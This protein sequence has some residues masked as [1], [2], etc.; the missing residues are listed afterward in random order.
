MGLDGKVAVVTGA[1]RGIGAAIAHQL[2]GE[3]AKV[4][5][6]GR[7][8]KDGREIESR[9]VHEGG[10]ALFVSADHSHREEVAAVIETAVD[11]FGSL[12]TLVNNAARQDLEDGTVLTVDDD[13]I[14]EMMQIHLHAA[15]WACRAAIPHMER[16]GG[17]SIVNISTI[18]S[19]FPRPG[20]LAY[21][22]SKGALNSLT[23]Q[24]AVDHALTNIR[25][26]ALILGRISASPRL[27]EDPEFRASSAR[28]SLLGR[29]GEP[30][31]VAS[32]CAFL[33][34]DAARFITG[35][36]VPMDG[37]AMLKRHELL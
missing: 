37:G 16:A 6:T 10:E 15:V 9:I 34:S 30:K 4:V 7:T 23:L 12:T 19:M 26:N 17:G 29:I 33:A 28:L 27:Y 2:A 18:G 35:A 22:V 24:L 3:G 25:A 1:T 11:A 31:E 32:A 14:V 5:L 8:E 13:V 36:L 20:A 21:A